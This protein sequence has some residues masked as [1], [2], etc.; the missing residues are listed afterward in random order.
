MSAVRKAIA[1][2]V[3]L[4]VTLVHAQTT[5]SDGK[6]RVYVA[7][8]ESWET[9]G[10]FGVSHG[11]GGGSVRG[12]ARPQ[13]AEIIKTFNERCPAV[14]I[15][16][17]K[18]RA[19]FAI[20]L[21]HEGGKGVLAHRNKVAVFNR[22]GDVIYSGSTRSIG[23][24]VKDACEAI[25]A[26]PKSGLGEALPAP[27]NP[28]TQ[29]TPATTT[30]TNLTPSAQVET[31]RVTPVNTAPTPVASPQGVPIR[32]TT[33][34]P[35]VAARVEPIQATASTPAPTSPARAEPLRIIP[36]SK[37]V[38]IAPSKPLPTVQAT[39]ASNP[40]G[41]IVSCNGTTFGRTP[42]LIPLLPGIYPVKFELAGYPD[43]TTEI[44]VEVAKPFTLVAQLN[45]TTGV[46]LK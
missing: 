13:T 1:P 29:P 31:G 23:T 28:A 40:P 19:N 7:D 33:P 6:V 41:A 36:T 2:L 44:T 8:S 43:W 20:V 14:T 5:P 11:S 38:V 4:A 17:A 15:T 27:A 39:F 9:S 24:S 18:D 3:C 22:E 21:D 32:A 10:G 25:S 16:D 37:P 35:T 45:S 34:T 12:G 42:F 30:G 46:M 26:A